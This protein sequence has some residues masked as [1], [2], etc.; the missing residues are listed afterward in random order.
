MRSKSSAGEE[1]QELHG[2]WRRI[3]LLFRLDLMHHGQG[4]QVLSLSLTSIE[5]PMVESSRAKRRGCY[6]NLGWTRPVLTKGLF[7]R[8]W[9]FLGLLQIVGLMFLVFG[10]LSLMYCWI[11]WVVD[12]CFKAGSDEVIF[13]FLI[14]KNIFRKLK[15]IFFFLKI[16]TEI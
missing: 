8:V 11:F 4:L 7:A 14:L 16:W 12:F 3:G 2:G 13:F 15:T 6:R 10:F 9:G 1:P 5:G